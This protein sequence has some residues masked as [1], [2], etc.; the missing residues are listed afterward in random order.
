MNYI[1]K[2]VVIDA[3]SQIIEVENLR[4]K[5]AHEKNTKT[6]IIQL[7]TEVAPDVD[8]SEKGAVCYTSYTVATQP[9]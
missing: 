1:A 2:N 3:L 8:P 5:D 9:M 6:R 4:D 7:V